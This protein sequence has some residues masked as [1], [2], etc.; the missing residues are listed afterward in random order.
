MEAKSQAVRFAIGGK[1][2]SKMGRVSAACHIHC[3]QPKKPLSVSADC[4]RHS[5]AAASPALKRLSRPPQ[6]GLPQH[7]YGPMALGLTSIVPSQIY[8]A[9]GGDSRGARSNSRDVN[10]VNSLAEPAATQNARSV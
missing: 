6:L 3:H 5:A 1:D 2:G 8:F 10:S 7:V 9:L 4:F